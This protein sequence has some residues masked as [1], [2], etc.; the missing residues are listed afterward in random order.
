MSEQANK[1]VQHHGSAS[2]TIRAQ[3]PRSS[4]SASSASVAGENPSMVQRRSSARN[5]RHHAN[6]ANSKGSARK[7]HSDGTSGKQPSFE[8]ASNNLQVRR[9]LRVSVRKSKPILGIAIEGGF[10]VSGQLL[11]R[12]VCVHVSIASSWSEFPLLL[13]SLSL[14]LA[15]IC[16]T[17]RSMGSSWPIDNCELNTTQHTLIEGEA[18]SIES[19]LDCGCAAALAALQIINKGSPARDESPRT[20]GASCGLRRPPMHARPS[21]HGRRLLESVQ[22]QWSDN[23]LARLAGDDVVLVAL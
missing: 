18:R 14:S 9:T 16:Q 23:S 3:Q 1:F 10:N 11:P 13:L 19:A 20:V 17:K 8:S 7:R 21:A 15:P 12:I 6:G 4:S 22:T 2:G 5:H